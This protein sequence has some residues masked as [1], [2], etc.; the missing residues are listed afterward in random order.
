MRRTE[1]LWRVL[2]GAVL[3][4]VGILRVQLYWQRRETV[5]LAWGVSEIAVALWLGVTGIGAA[6]RY[7]LR[8]GRVEGRRLSNDR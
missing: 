8:A 7:D 3:L 2:M 5:Q 6:R 1:I 4:I